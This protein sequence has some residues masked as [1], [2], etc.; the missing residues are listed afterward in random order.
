MLVRATNAAFPGPDNVALASATHPLA[1][2]GTFSN[3]MTPAAPSIASWNAGIAQLDQLV[4]HD[5]IIEGYKAT[6]VLH[7]VQQRGIWTVLL[8][9]QMDP[10]VTAGN[11]NA[12]NVIKK[13]SGDIKRVQ[14]K[15]WTNTTTN[16]ALQTNADNGFQFRWRKKF[17]S[18]TW[19][20]ENQELINYGISGRFDTGT[21]E[22]RCLLFN[23][24]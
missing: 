4:D 8:G 1:A 10:T 3:L 19:I 11:F 17:N 9:S 6:A 21:S 5:G 18:K 13:Y 7:P 12:I 20:D 15:Y 22:P 2:G 16:W 24:A 23:N 14:L